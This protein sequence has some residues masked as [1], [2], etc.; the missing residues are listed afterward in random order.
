MS[1][2]V[3]SALSVLLVLKDAKMQGLEY[4]SFQLNTVLLYDFV[5]CLSI[6]FNG[7]MLLLD[8]VNVLAR[9]LSG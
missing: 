3:G 2:P 7:L 9:A 1:W 8:F 4:G 6:L 5:F